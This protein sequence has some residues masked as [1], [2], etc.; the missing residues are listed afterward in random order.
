MLQWILGSTNTN[1][2]GLYAEFRNRTGANYPFVGADGTQLNGA[3][4]FSIFSRNTNATFVNDEGLIEEVG[5]DVLRVQYNPVTLEQLGWLIEG[6]RADLITYN[7]AN[8]DWSKVRCTVTE[9]YA[10]D[11]F[12]GNTAQ[13]IVEDTSSSTSHYYQSKSFAHTSGQ[14]YCYWGV[15]E[16]DDRSKVWIDF[17]DTIFGSAS[18][19]YFDL[20]TG[21][22][23]SQFSGIDAAGVILMG[24]NRYLCWATDTA[25]SSG[26]AGAVFGLAVTDGVSGYTGNG[27]A[28]V[29]FYGAQ[30]EI[31]TFPSSLI[32]T[33]ATSVIRD[34]DEL[35]IP[36]SSV[37]GWQDGVSFSARYKGISAPGIGSSPQYL[38]TIDDGTTS[39][40]IAVYRGADNYIYLN[41]VDGGVTQATVQGPQV[42]GSHTV[43]VEITVI[44]DDISMSVSVDD[45]AAV[46]YGPDTSGTIPTGLTDLVIG[47]RSDMARAWFGVVSSYQIKALP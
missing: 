4:P 13:K 34:A 47:N 11:L 8:T 15:F 3:P 20:I 46:T 24:N 16:A 41:V 38:A 31:G 36:L 22:V 44:E 27:T 35:K 18:T 14:K 21:A 42:I 19:C 32:V 5:A 29:I 17:S 33:G 6:Q 30:A 45:G 25:T 7:A 37:A 26:T 2:N 10:P 43:D 28:G 1:L 39:N 40:V 12:G 9:N 23:T